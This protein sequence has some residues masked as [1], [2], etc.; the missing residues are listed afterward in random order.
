MPIESGSLRPRP[1]PHLFLVSVL[2][3]ITLMLGVYGHMQAASAA[4]DPVDFLD[5]LYATMQLFTLNASLPPG[6]KPISLDIARV[7]AMLVFVY[8]LRAVFIVATN[9]FQRLFRRLNAHTVVIGATPRG[10]E[11]GRLLA[12]WDGKEKDTLLLIDTAVQPLEEAEAAMPRVATLHGDTLDPL[13][14]AEG[15]VANAKSVI[16]AGE[17]EVRN[18]EVLGRLGKYLAARGERPERPKPCYVEV[19]QLFS[20]AAFRRLRGL[21]EYA[22][23]LL[24]TPYTPYATVVRKTLMQHPLDGSGIRPGDPARPHLFL[25]GFGKMGENMV[26]HAVRMGHYANERKIRITIADPDAN[27]LWK[28]FLYRYPAI[29][30]LAEVTVLNNC[31]E[32]DVVQGF[33]L[34]SGADEL[35]TV[36]LC[37]SCPGRTLEQALHLPD[38]LL[39][40]VFQILVRMETG[41]SLCLLDRGLCDDEAAARKFKL[42]G[43]IED[44]CA[45]ASDNV[46]DLARSAHEFYREKARAEGR[47]EP[48]EDV[49]WERL[50]C[51]LMDS[52]RQQSDHIPVKLRTV[53]ARLVP[54]G[55][56]AGAPP[57]SFSDGEIE[58]LARMEHSRWC[59]ERLLAG[60]RAVPAGEAKDAARK[61][62]PYLV[63]YDELSEAIKDY[64]RESVRNIVR[65]TERT[66]QRLVRV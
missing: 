36:A 2:V 8:T 10:R 20:T 54:R 18:I 44:M 4:G 53:G 60:W 34:E 35:L 56:G 43:F 23:Y 49:P 57:F 65:L 31:F 29:P 42:F 5:S 38:A 59:A 28:R 27:A 19:D 25:S 47:L 32:D 45:L 41:M 40:K 1:F 11:M 66:S 7:L 9:Q 37:R 12:G 14:M 50:D 39:E 61:T 63:P 6:R 21:K 62:T 15:R 30:S 3:V 52:N 55:E 22:P 17:D 51:D 58:L 33:L 64:D 24:I 48:A 16:I 46:D 26:L 13:V